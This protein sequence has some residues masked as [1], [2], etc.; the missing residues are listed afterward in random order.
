MIEH[1]S[2]VSNV[3][4]QVPRFG[5]DSRSRVLHTISLTF[6]AS[7]G[8]IFRALVAGAALCIPDAE[9]LRPGRELLDFI[10]E[11]RID[12]ATLPA[13]AL[14]AMPFEQLPEL[15]TLTVGGEALSSALADRW[16]AGRRLLNGY[17]PTE[18]AVGVTVAANWAHGRRPPLGRLLPDVRGY[19]LDPEMQLVPPGV[20]GELYLGGQCL[21][22]GYHNRPDLTAQHFVPDMVGEEPGG[23]LYRTGD[24]VRW[25]PDGQLDFLGRADDQVKIRGHRVEPDEISSVLRERQEVRDVAVAASTDGSG[26][27]R[28]V[29]YVVPVNKAEG[30]RGASKELVNEWKRASELAAVEY[31]A[32]GISD[33]ALNFSGWRSTYTGEA[34]PVEEMSDWADASVA[35][36]REYEPREVLEIGCGTGLV[37]YRLAPHCR[38]YVGTDFS[39]SLLGVTRQHLSLLHDSGCEVEL[40]HRAADQLDEWPEATFDCVVLN[41]VVQYFPDSEYLVNVLRRAIALTRDGGVVFIGDVRNLEL[42]ECFH[43]LVQLGVAAATTSRGDLAQRVRRHVGLERELIVS[44]ELFSRLANESPRV[45]HLRVMPK[46]G[47]GHN[48]LTEFRYDVV[49]E[50]ARDAPRDLQPTWT[51]W[52]GET[53]ERGMH[54]IRSAL[55]NNP[56]RLGVRDIP[57][58]RTVRGAALLERL[59]GGHEFATV[60][61]LRED[62]SRIEAA[63]EP[64]DLRILA[65]EAGYEVELSWLGSDGEG[66][67]H[68]VFWRAGEEPHAVSPPAQVA[69]GG[70]QELTNNPAE[71]VS[72]RDRASRLRDFLLTRIPEYMVPSAFVFL[73]ELPLTSTGKLD[74]GA[75]PA[76]DGDERRADRAKSYAPPRTSAEKVLAKIWSDVLQLD[77][78]GIRDNFFELGGDSILSIRVVAKA[79]ESGVKVTSQ[80]AH[81][82]QTIEELAAAADGD[83]TVEPASGG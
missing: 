77:R 53:V 68:A 8:E 62:V 75:L 27:L 13:S 63:V 22:R 40:R 67:F 58:A 4:G 43:G 48:E 45:S 34:I 57:N 16:G 3:A 10:R 25:L 61:E 60:A 2:L 9:H 54:A 36:I 26:E 38:R 12:T 24:R 14:G 31:L 15:R 79:A 76:P 32:A 64:D 66:K 55:G 42:L 82:Y 71:A 46:E 41:S 47:R 21:A 51:E 69:S 65:R 52:A 44:P 1:R 74:R 78:V 5:I 56:E 11:E 39:A 19:V 50:I 33:P 7:L 80:D 73:G 20:P 83:V 23:R 35:R 18:T 28:L 37:L 70:W 30:E 59:R 49:L 81:R 29:A 17:G 6:D 72:D